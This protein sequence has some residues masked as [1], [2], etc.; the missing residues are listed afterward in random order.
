MTLEVRPIAAS[1]E[2]IWRDLFQQ[3]ATFYKT[4][5]SEDVLKRVWN[6][7]MS[8]DHPERGFVAV[9]ENKVVGFAH[10]QRQVDTFRASVSWFLDDLFVT[11]EVRGQGVANA[12]LTHLRHYANK[13]GGGDI[14]WITAAD[15]QTAMSVYDGLATKTSWVFYEMPEDSAQ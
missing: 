12:L 2:V 8:A 13:H 7:L 6:W 15:N 10:L 1:D 11:P 9:L 14:R 5:F 3:Y 4:S